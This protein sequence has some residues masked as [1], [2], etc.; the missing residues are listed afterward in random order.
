MAGYETNRTSRSNRSGSR[1]SS[2]SAKRKGVGFGYLLIWT[3]IICLLGFGI[4][5]LLTSP[6]FEIRQ[7]H[8]EGNQSLNIEHIATA[9]RVPK[10]SNIF[11][12]WILDRQKYCGRI[13]ACDPIIESD[14]VAIDLPHALRLLIVERQPYAVLDVPNSISYMMDDNRVAFKTTALNQANSPFIE[15]PPTLEKVVEGSA[16]PADI[17]RHVSAA[18]NLLGMIAERQ[19]GPLSDIE[20]VSVDQ[21][22]NV[23]LKLHS[24]LLIKLGQ[25]EGLPQ[26]LT[27]VETALTA[28]PSL[29]SKAQYLDFTTPRPAIMEKPAPPA[30]LSTSSA[31]A[32]AAVP[33]S[34]DIG[35]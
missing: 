4:H 1:R 33:L 25:A 28:D 3:T 21:Y 31:S 29:V 24:Q 13:Q 26:R 17:D 23:N 32:A 22:D 6:Y 8:I 9:E 7:V 18:Y 34:A 27:L 11:L 10:H 16:L 15:I 14:S 19:I 12:F 35:Q 20:S 2:R 5:W 30:T